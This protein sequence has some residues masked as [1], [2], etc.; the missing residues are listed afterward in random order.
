MIQTNKLK[1]K[2]DLIK[3]AGTILEVYMDGENYY[4]G[5]YL[6]DGSGTLYYPTI[7]QN[8]KDYIDS[9]IMLNELYLK[10]EDSIVTRN[11]REG[12]Q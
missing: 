12:E 10:S 7:K 9:R 4:L 11:S 3:S 6:T 2:H 1:K 8:L 5:S